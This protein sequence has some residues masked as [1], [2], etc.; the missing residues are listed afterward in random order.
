[1]KRVIFLLILVIS[2]LQACDSR[3]VST[4]TAVNT[5]SGTQT[6]VPTSTATPMPDASQ[7]VP[8]PP[9]RDLF[10]ITQR[11]RLKSDAP[12]PRTVISGQTD[13]PLGTQS[14]IQLVDLDKNKPFTVAATLRYKT[15]N[16]YF[17]F[18]QK[19]S[20][21]QEDV[22]RAARNFES[23]ILPSVRRYFGDF[24]NPGVD[25]DPH[26][27]IVHANIPQV[28]GYF[29]GIDEYP[30][31]V[32][33][34]SNQHETIYIN[35]GHLRVG[36]T[37]YLNTLAH[38]LQHA[39]EFTANPFSEVWVNEGLSE[40]SSDLAGYPP[41]LVNT[42]F[43]NADVQLNAWDDE[44]S[45]TPPHY[46]ASFLF[47]KYLF[48]RYGGYEGIKDFFKIE[49][50]GVEQVDAYLS[51]FNTDFDD[52]FADWTAANLVNSGVGG[53]Y[54]YENYPQRVRG[55]LVKMDVPDEK[56]GQQVSQYGA[57]YFQIKPS[58][59]FSIAFDG[60][61]S[62]KLLPTDA[63]SGSSFWWGNRGDAIDSTLT[64]EFDLSNVQK[65]TLNYWA[66]YDIEKDFDFSYLEVSKDG[67]RTWDILKATSTTS[68]SALDSNYGDGYTGKSGGSDTPKWVNETANLS[69]YVGGKV[70]VRFEYISDEAVST[71]GFAIDDI[72]IPE[73]SFVDPV[74][75]ESLWKAEGFVKTSNLVK[76]NFIVQ[77]IHRDRQGLPL[78]VEKLTLNSG[79]VGE[80]TASISLDGY[81]DSVL[82][83]SGSTRVTTEKAEFSVSIK[84]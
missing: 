18:D 21:P 83:V 15:A 70:L 24:W 2:I 57:R 68:E 49:K 41:T 58:S 35:S 8:V 72:S 23:V 13:I 33:N 54:G 32:N 27:Y 17:W 56:D 1:M 78:K 63:H 61:D 34:L 73:I 65:A 14:N 52:V 84:Q 69:A 62:V 50:S 20:T 77:L 29:S 79:N 37:E 66:W 55:P 67:G 82:V 3:P 75:G 53:R 40:L 59:D 48:A 19:D 25:G 76:Q 39:V 60:A 44:V 30:K 71:N 74:E 51:R 22:E 5:P 36:S 46:G 6:G 47:M 26:L 11:L 42:Y 43:P 80:I 10:E 31:V 64:R 28:A 7:I 81:V 45:R 16:A 38:E 4:P 12:I 9:Q